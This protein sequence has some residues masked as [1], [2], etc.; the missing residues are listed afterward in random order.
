MPKSPCGPGC[1]PRRGTV[2]EVAAPRV[3]LRLAGA[4]GFVLLG[5][6]LA[7]AL[8]LLSRGRRDRLISGWFRGLM[9]VLG[10]R[11]VAAGQIEAGVLV[12]SNHVSWLDVV[13]LQALRRMRLLAKAEVRSWPF[14]G[15]LAA[16]IG[17]VFIDR[18]RLRTL[19][20]AVRAV[21]DGLRSGAVIGFFPEGTTWCGRASGTYRPALFQAA[22]DAGAPVQPV[23]L[24]FR[25][26][27]GA[28]SA[29]AAFV[30]DATLV[31]S[32]LTVAR[33]RGLVLE[34][35]VLPALNGR[36][37]DRRDLAQRA[38]RLCS[39]GG[40]GVDRGV[41]SENPLDFHRGRGCTLPG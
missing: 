23:A 16:R 24:R 1:L 30:G 15:A 26:G 10:I 3:A 8:P 39:T 25:L 7:G 4:A 13:A 2:P 27:D 29:I 41:R 22:V 20:G 37:A 32:V 35:T 6:V 17:T 21:A 9:R 34:A 28:P 5:A 14:V 38:R 33:V 19:P 31:G 12:V 36:A 18:E 40:F 11:F